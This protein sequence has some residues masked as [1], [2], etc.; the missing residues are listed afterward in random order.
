MVDQR[1]TERVGRVCRAYGR[2]STACNDD[3]MDEQSKEQAGTMADKLSVADKPSVASGSNAMPIESEAISAFI[4]AQKIIQNMD[5]RYNGE[6]GA[7]E[8]HFIEE[9]KLMTIRSK[10][11]GELRR[12]NPVTRSQSLLAPP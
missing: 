12:K 11:D 4:K 9:L 7:G 10:L 2:D 6:S 5:L 8:K 3:D 1:P